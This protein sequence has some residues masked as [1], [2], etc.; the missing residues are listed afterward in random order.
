MT[1]QG[2]LDPQTFLGTEETVR[3]RVKDILEQV[4]ASGVRQHIFNVGHGL[5]PHTSIEAVSWAVDEIR[6]FKL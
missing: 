6:K 3:T 5:L 4:A 2:N 1:V